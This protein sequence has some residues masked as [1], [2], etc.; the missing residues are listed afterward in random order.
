MPYVDEVL[1][2]NVKG[3]NCPLVEME[4]VIAVFSDGYASTVS[5]SGGLQIKSDIKKLIEVDEVWAMCARKSPVSAQV[6]I[7]GRFI[8]AD[9][10]IGM[11]IY[12]RSRLGFFDQYK[13]LAEA[14]A[15]HWKIVFQARDPFR[16]E[17]ASDYVTGN[18]V[19][20]DDK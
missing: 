20:L 3:F 19:D 15:A 17:S 4:R 12:E 1:N 6:R 18:V 5:Y 8:E 2:G 16:G 7:L 9:T 13:S 10:F 14:V 11:Q